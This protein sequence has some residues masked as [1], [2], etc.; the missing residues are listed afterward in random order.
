MSSS[1]R[2]QQ[3]LSSWQQMIPVLPP[4]VSG[5]KCRADFQPIDQLQMTQ[6]GTGYFIMY[7]L[8]SYPHTNEKY[9]LTG[10]MDGDSDITI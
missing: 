8:I 1:P 10:D 7:I 5:G 6:C 2:H 9:R 4:V 3:C